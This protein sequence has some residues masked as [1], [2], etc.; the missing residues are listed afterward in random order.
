MVNE[1]QLLEQKE[2]RDKY[3]NKIEVLNKVKSLLLIQET[4]LA[5]IK[6]VADYYE[7]ET[8]TIY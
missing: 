3:V 5:T 4:E 7:V 6:Q 2:T 1:E 8:R